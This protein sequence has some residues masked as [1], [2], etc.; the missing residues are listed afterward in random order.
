MMPR[1]VRLGVSRLAGPVAVAAA[2]VGALA[3]SADAQAICTAPHSAP[4]LGGGGAISTAEPLTG[5]M[6]FAVLHQRSD[7]FFNFQGGTQ[8][9]IA[10]GAFRNT[11]AFLSGATGIV[12]GMDVWLQLS[13]HDLRYSDEG[14]ERDRTGLGDVRAA[15]RVT[16]AL[17]GLPRV[18]IAVRAGVKVPGSDFPIDATVIPLTGGSAGLGTECRVGACPER[19]A[20]PPQRSGRIPVAGGTPRDRAEARR[21]VVRPGHDRESNRGCGRRVGNCGSRGS[22]PVGTGFP[23][24]YGTSPDASVAA[25]CELG[26]GG[27]YD[28][29]QWPAGG[30][31]AQPARRQRVEPG[32]RALLGCAS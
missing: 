19:V 23:A 24:R 4:T 27:R 13:V 32:V 18:P 17:F 6:Q 16:P 21:R 8:E 22:T 7:D 15:V 20:R 26:D 31:R 28:R 9:L 25:R 2:M 5:W 30:C 12:D 11:S 29:A 10:S 3:G 14:G 1:I